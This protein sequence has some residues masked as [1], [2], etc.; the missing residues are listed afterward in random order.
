MPDPDDAH[1]TTGAAVALS[2]SEARLRLM[3]DAVPAM[4]TYLD[5]QERFLFCN[6]PY[7]DMLGKQAEDVL[8]RDLKQIL[9]P[10]LHERLAPSRNQVLGGTTARYERQHARSDG[11]MRDLS[12]TFV[13]HAEGDVVVGFFCLTLDVTEVKAL[14]RKLAH[15]AGHDVLTGVPNRA[16]YNDRLAQA[17]ERN[18]RH[19]Q[20]FALVYLDVDHF[21][22]VNDT[23]GHAVGDQLLRGFAARIQES[24]RAVDVVA[25]LG[26]DEFALILEGPISADNVAQVAHKIGAATRAPFRLGELSLVV[27]TSIGVALADDPCTPAEEL[28]ARA[29]AAL[30]RAKAQGRDTFVVHTA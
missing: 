15:L 17:I 8:G 7:L 20:A 16:L 14:E 10:D 13:P 19:R 27:T 6:R 9:G 18:K 4:I 28:A 1:S 25:R 21:K 30:Y 5:T 11:S 2:Q 24:I 3:I 12:V 29:D 22:R 23:H 26:D